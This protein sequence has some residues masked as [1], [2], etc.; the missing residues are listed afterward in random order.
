MIMNPLSPACRA[1]DLYFI[2]ILQNALKIGFQLTVHRASGLE[3]KVKMLQNHPQ[4]STF[5][6][7]ECCSAPRFAGQFFAKD[8]KQDNFDSH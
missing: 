4:R 1:K 2:T 6:E 3:R 5:G 7:F 8:A